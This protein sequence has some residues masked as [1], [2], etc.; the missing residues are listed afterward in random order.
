MSG[1]RQI[2]SNQRGRTCAEASGTPS[3]G[4]SAIARDKL[5]LLH[6]AIKAAPTCHFPIRN[7]E[8][9]TEYI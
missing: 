9:L 3:L 4:I 2:T 1:T 5:Q 7:P 8:L 6:A